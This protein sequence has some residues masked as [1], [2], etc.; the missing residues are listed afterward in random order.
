M[1]RALPRPTPETRH[2]WEGTRAGELRLQ[3]C[4]ACAGVWFPPR[5]VCPSCASLDVRVFA[6]SGRARL[7]MGA[8]AGPGPDSLQGQFELPFGTAG[9][10]TLLTLGALRFM[11][12]TGVTLEQLAGVVVAQSQWAA[13][14]P[15]AARRTP[16][17][18]DGVLAAEPVAWPFTR[19]MVCLVSHGGGALVLTSAERARDL[20]RTPV[21]VLGTGEATGVPMASQLRD[22]TR[23]RA[24]RSAGEQPSPRRGSNAPTWIT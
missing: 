12:E 14:N 16:M 3:R 2:F 22:V 19:P 5:P 15:R 13:L 18:V 6:A 1:E 11:Q 20:A 7:G 8:F 17:S 4:A 10:T 9:P 23:S 24:F 21:Y